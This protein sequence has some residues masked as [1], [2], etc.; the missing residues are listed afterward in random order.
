MPTPDFYGPN[1]V[2][3]LAVANWYRRRIIDGELAPGDKIPSSVTMAAELGV[4]EQVAYQAMQQLRRWG[5]TEAHRGSGTRVRR[6][7]ERQVTDMTVWD[8]A[9]HRV[10]RELAERGIVVDEVFTEDISAK[11]PTLEEATANDWPEGL[12]VMQIVRH[13]WSGGEVVHEVTRLVSAET[14]TLRYRVG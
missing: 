13:Y 1:R 8:A 9:A 6:R 4:S 11:I 3:Y 12:P 14:T 5:Y 2:A 10:A 7:P